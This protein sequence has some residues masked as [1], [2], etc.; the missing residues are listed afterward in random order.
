MVTASAFGM[1]IPSNKALQ[2]KFDRLHK[3]GTEKS[4]LMRNS[5]QIEL[6]DGSIMNISKQEALQSGLLTSLMEDYQEMGSK[7]QNIIFSLPS[8]EN[9]QKD[10]LLALLHLSKSFK[11]NRLN[12]ILQQNDDKTINN[13]IELADFFDIPVVYQNL[14]EPMAKKLLS[15]TMLKKFI[16]S[17]EAAFF[18]PFKIDYDL[19]KKVKQAMTNQLGISNLHY[20]STTPII[21]C[22][23]RSF[24]MSM[25]TAF[26][27]NNLLFVQDKSI[28]QLDISNYKVTTLIPISQDIIQLAI[29]SDG[30]LLAT[31]ISNQVSVFNIK[32]KENIRVALI[33]D[34]ITAIAFDIDNK[35]LAVAYGKGS[36]DFY[37][38]SDQQNI[39]RIKTVSLGGFEE[40]RQL[41]YL[42]PNILAVLIGDS[43]SLLDLKNLKAP[44]RLKLPN[45]CSIN[46]NKNDNQWTKS[47]ITSTIYDNQ[48]EL[49]F[50]GY[51]DGQIEIL[52]VSDMGN[53]QLITSFTGILTKGNLD[54][55]YGDIRILALHPKLPL[56]IVVDTRNNL[57]IWDISEKSIPRLITE[58][59]SNKDWILD[60]IE[61]VFFNPNS[62]DFIDLSRKSITLNQLPF[63]ESLQGLSMQELMLI[64]F[65]E[66]EN[67]LELCVR[68][69]KALI[70]IFDGLPEEIQKKYADKL[71]RKYLLLVH[72]GKNKQF[73]QKI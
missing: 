10:S 18:Q 12:N 70:N 46:K 22:E 44:Q 59:I 4:N 40:I 9:K 30:N 11:Q 72:L 29:S 17:S 1:E 63:D 33:E 20:E 57:N 68:H 15:P 65:L 13:L 37:N 43:F 8:I 24:L 42:K 16:N 23:R 6:T 60:K 66:Q 56:L 38:I 67:K 34:N 28:K 50:L 47:T 5:V 31:A 19:E 2:E 35:T 61:N 39:Q 49:L 21:E 26:H 32:D 51:A 3:I 55:S 36:I 25:P 52:N 64:A 62:A 54:S 27:N 53:L 45:Q 71:I 58:I 7:N 69:N 48:H 73:C 14:P 41:T